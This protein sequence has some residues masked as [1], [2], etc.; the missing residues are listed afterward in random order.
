MNG[1]NGETIH[2]SGLIFSEAD[3]RVFIRHE[4]LFILGAIGNDG[5]VYFIEKTEDF[6]AY[7]FEEYV[8]EIRMDFLID[9]PAE[10]HIKFIEKV[11]EGAEE[12]G[13]KFYTSKDTISY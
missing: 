7:Y 1:V 4:N 8:N 11:L 6:D 9:M 12:Y 2:P 3:L 13:V 5:S 10:E